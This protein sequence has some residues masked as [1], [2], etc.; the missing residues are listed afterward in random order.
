MA[1]PNKPHLESGQI[2][3]AFTLPGADGVPHSPL[4]Y[5]QRE[6]LVLLF[7][8]RT[9]SSETRGILLAFSKAYPVIREDRCSILAITPDTVMSNLLAQEELHLPYPLLADPKGEVISQYTRW[10]AT[11][12]KLKPSIVL[13]DRNNALHQQWIAEKEDGLPAIEELLDSL[14]YLNTLCIS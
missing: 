9:A 11:T 10:D 4:D 14:T 1:Q 7:L 12:N 6:H 8:P 2:I 3:P 13:A 5:K